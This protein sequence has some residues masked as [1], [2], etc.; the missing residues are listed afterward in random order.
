VLKHL[1]LTLSD[2]EQQMLQQHF[3]WL[4]DAA[5]QQPQAGMHRDYH[6]RNL[7]LQPDGRLAVIDFQDMVW[8]P[9]TY[10]AVSLLKDCYIKW[11]ADLVQQMM[12]QWQQ[13]L[14]SNKV[15]AADISAE[16]FRLWFDWMGLQRHIKVCGIF[17]RLYHRDQKSGYLAD[18]PRV[19]QYVLDVTSAYPQL[20]QLDVWLRQKIKPALE[21]IV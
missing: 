9:V 7:M 6:S 16:Q 21:A 4:A 18:L 13:Q 2:D 8:G 1:Q 11:P 3:Q 12:W 19:F 14:V 20:Q 10:D 17:C 15:V 5:L